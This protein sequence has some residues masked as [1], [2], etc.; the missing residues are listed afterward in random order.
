MTDLPGIRFSN[1]S[2]LTPDDRPRSGQS[3]WLAGLNDP[4][5]GKSLRLIDGGPSRS[6]TVEDLARETA[7]SRSALAQPAF[8]TGFRREE[9]ETPSGQGARPEGAGDVLDS[10]SRSPTKRNAALADVYG[11]AGRQLVRNAG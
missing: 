4:C 9:P 8:L 5:V 7:I 1:S 3:G 11:A 2:T 6:W 10:T